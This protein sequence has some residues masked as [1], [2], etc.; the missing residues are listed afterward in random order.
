MFKQTYS[1]EYRFLESQRGIQ[2]YP[3]RIPIICEKSRHMDLPDID[4]NK[5]L[6]PW[7]LTV[8]QFIYVIRKRIKL[9]PEE[10]IFLFIGDTISTSSAIMGELYN[11][12]KD[13]DGFL[14]IQYTKENTF[15]S[16]LCV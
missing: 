11:Y 15:G 4:K 7:D 3:N 6:V 12:H 14:Y 2:N 9:R 1:F 16:Y 10:A 8:A 5:Y 13:P